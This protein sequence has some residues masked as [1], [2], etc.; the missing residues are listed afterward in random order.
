M[1]VR[2]EWMTAH[3]TAVHVVPEGEEVGEYAVTAPLGLVLSSDEAVVVE[4]SALELLDLAQRITTG[5]AALAPDA[6]RAFL[7]QTLAY[8]NKGA[9][10]EAPVVVEEG[11]TAAEQILADRGLTYIC[12]RCAGTNGHNLVHVRHGNGGGHNEP[13]PLDTRPVPETVG[14]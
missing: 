9:Q 14:E 4:G 10:A 13:C 8:L 1:S 2:V 5:V 7:D 3:Q 6:C 11:P 12:P